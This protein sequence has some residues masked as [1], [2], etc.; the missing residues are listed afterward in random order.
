[1]L[2]RLKELIKKNSKIFILT[3]NLYAIFI[4]ILGLLKHK[5]GAGNHLRATFSLIKQSPIINGLPI[6]ITIE[7]SNRC[8]CKCPVCETG[9]GILGRSSENMKFDTFRTIIDKIYLHTNTLMFYFMGEPF[10][11]KDSYK[12]IRYAKDN[13]ISFITTCTNG[14]LVNPIKLVQSGIDEVNFQ[15]G[16]IT[17]E[18]HE[19]YRK[20]STLEK[21]MCN[22]KETLR[23]RNE[24]NIKMRIV[25]GFILMK[26]NEH[27][28]NDFKIL[29]QNLGVDEALIIDPCVRT[30]EQGQEMLPTDKTHWIYNPE[31][32]EKG[33]LIPKILAD[34]CPWIY[35]SMTILVN[36]DVV[37][38][39]R[40]ALGQYVMGNILDQELD[41]IW[42][43]KK[44]KNFRRVL[45]NDQRKI[46]ICS[47]CSGY[48]VSQI[49]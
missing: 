31:A 18:T 21:V 5:R 2:T 8:N 43:G 38:C 33:Q 28:V 7:P 14:D 22:L 40:D 34:K 39:C 23:L 16:G 17:Q 32:F 45:N 25:C 29:M 9:S 11:N 35:Y 15:I 37:P 36:G 49:K 19:M 20:G 46:N 10:I 13:K 42:N 12:M 26:H 4:G 24:L 48:G 3:S 1:M 27:E 41:D 30:I 47:L 44:F 6:N